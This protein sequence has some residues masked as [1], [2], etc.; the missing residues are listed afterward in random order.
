[1]T[2]R[3][4]GPYELESLIG[5]GGMGEV[6]RAND[7][8]RDRLVAVK[9]LP[10]SLC[11]DQ[12]FLSRFR[13]ESHVAARLREPHVIPI[14]DF[15]E[16]DGRLFID[17]RLVDGQ[18]LGAILAEGPIA[19][20]R[21]IALLAQVADALEAAH[22][23]GLVHRD[24]KPSNVLV[25]AND[26]VYVVDFGIARS[27]GSTR[28]SLTITGATI[29][30][31]DYMAPERFTN[32]PIDGRVDVYSLA[33]VL[34][35]CLTAAH[36]FPGG[37]LPALLYAHLYADP[38]RP[39]DQVAGLPPA[40]DEV[41]S[42][43]M[44]KLPDDRYPTPRELIAAARAALEP[45]PVPGAAPSAAPTQVPVPDPRAPQP[46]VLPPGDVRPPAPAPAGVGLR[47]ADGA[48]NSANRLPSPV[49]PN[50]LRPPEQPLTGNGS[51]HGGSGA[52]GGH[53]G[54]GL[55]LAGL[56]VILLIA[57]ALT[58]LL[59]PQDRTP[60][61]AGT[62]AGASQTSSGASSDGPTPS[63]RPG[64]T[65]ARPAASIAV[66]T[67]D[68]GPIAVDPMPEH[69]VVAP[70]GRYAYIANV[71]PQEISV[72][73][74]TTR[75]ITSHIPVPAGPPH[76]IT[77]SPDGKVGYVTIYN[78]D[79]S[80]NAVVFID[81]ST[82]TVTST[83][84]VGHRP[85]APSTSPDG[86]LLYVPLHNEG[87]VQVLDTTTAKEVASYP[88]VPNPH[89]ITV[90]ADGSRGY[91]A[92]HESGVVS[93]LDL[94]HNG[95][96]LTTIPVGKSPHSITISPDGSRV[97]VVCY[98]SND[99]WIIDPTTNQV[100][101]TVPVGLKPQDVTYAPDGKHLYTANVDGGT[102]SVVDTT[103]YGVTATIATGRS[104]T[105][106]SVLPDGKTAYVTNLDDATVR[107]L[108]TSA[109]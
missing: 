13:R 44:A 104:P 89:W 25:T 59:W 27:V 96:V 28:T 75:T 30:T 56:L 66:P 11:H 20:A 68:G 14:H 97:A 1:M 74:T 106:I 53:R 21:A 71:N 7:L 83:V 58:F 52:G 100:A 46:G 8:R 79:Y 54:R 48:H 73:D 92:N 69:I 99:L 35:E 24:V 102:V 26:F 95:Q 101:K 18:D 57:G 103:T 31:L 62:P 42:R 16:I 22:A 61:A 93:V 5:V 55:V 76:F 17:M 39:S 10:E 94:A 38:P 40:L 81:T 41:V 32:Q 87:R 82:N 60:T 91:T 49:P 12:E 80:Y 64:P 86:R 78:A 4:F 77:F 105:S 88:V 85:F 98:D 3:Q 29:G 19:P 67:V 51:G 2:S 84:P 72:L 33:C 34:A 108:R 107:V 9:L 6:W 23:D 65:V 90:S 109:D 70:N 15:G 47:S 36:P 63:A 45:A 43:G 37:D 50:W